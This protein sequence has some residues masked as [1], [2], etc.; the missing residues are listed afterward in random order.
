MISACLASYL[1]IL[2]ARCGYI[3]KSII[4]LL[5]N[6]FEDQRLNSAQGA[7]WD[8]KRRKV[9]PGSSNNNA[10]TKTPVDSRLD[11]SL[12]MTTGELAEHSR[13]ERETAAAEI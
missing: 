13:R 3:K 4:K 9:I 8:R 1:R 11:M 12:G 5:T 2:C 7:K 6:S 10:W